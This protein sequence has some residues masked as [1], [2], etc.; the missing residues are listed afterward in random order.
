MNLRMVRWVDIW[1]GIPLAYICSLT[2]I[3]L[4]LFRR[5]RQKLDGYSRILLIKFWGIGNVAMLLPAARSLKNRYP[6][7][8]I[9][10]LT[11]S[12]NKAIAAAGGCFDE[13]YTISSRTF[14]SFISTA[15][16]NFMRLRK[17]DYGLVI[18]FEQ[19]ARFSALFCFFI[20][21]R[22]SIG[23]H[24]R[25]QHRH[26]LFTDPVPYDNGIHIVS[27]FSLLAEKA[28]AERYGGV[29]KGPLLHYLPGDMKKVSDLL[30]ERT[31]LK[32]GPLVVLH[33]GTSG[34]FTLRRWPA[35]YFAGLADRII[36]G[37]AGTVVFSGMP[38]ESHAVKEIIALMH[39]RLQAVDASGKLDFGAFIALLSIADLVI[40]ADT[41]PVHLASCL[42]TPVAGLYG[43]NT[44][45]LY[46]PWGEKGMFFYKSFPCSPC[47]TNFNAK[48]HRCRHP[49]GQ[50]ACMRALG[51]EEVLSGVSE[52]YFKLRDRAGHAAT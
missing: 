37:Y 25:G 43:P 34:N 2:G 35:E 30:Q 42:N 26:M 21:R 29:N 13:V 17:A 44:P 18:D 23:F 20:S 28:G 8:R 22:D 16:I 52:R 50:G 41:A 51:I 47:I 9:D 39:N 38:E 3:F 4:R 11:L 32:K 12:D 49:Q 36:E 46:G 14:P 6:H 5:R 1:L 40:S 48:I 33:A 19:F 10:F 7:A 24:T 31:G 27:S 15:F 45:L